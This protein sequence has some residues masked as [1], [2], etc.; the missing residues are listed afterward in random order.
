MGKATFWAF[1]T[2]TFG[3]P[4]KTSYYVHAYNRLNFK[5]IYLQCI[6]LEMAK[7]LID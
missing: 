6:L 3:H 2:N 1:F 7:W 5:S 4:G